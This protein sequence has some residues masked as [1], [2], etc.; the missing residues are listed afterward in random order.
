MA[1]RAVPTDE[2]LPTSRRRSGRTGCTIP[3]IKGVT[4]MKKILFIA[5][6]AGAAFFIYKKKAA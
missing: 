6:L 5:A 2:R 1:P 3:K 4:P